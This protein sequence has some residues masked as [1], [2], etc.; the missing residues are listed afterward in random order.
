M[1]IAYVYNILQK[2][3]TS[4]MTMGFLQVRL[5]LPYITNKPNF[6]PCHNLPVA[7]L[8]VIV[9]LFGLVP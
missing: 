1:T 4:Y 9:L 8:F 6:F 7:F 3:Q 2:K 5:D